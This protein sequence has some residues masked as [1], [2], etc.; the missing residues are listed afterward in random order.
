MTGAGY[1]KEW[2]VSAAPRIWEVEAI[3][4]SVHVLEGGLARKDETATVGVFRVVQ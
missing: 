2:G 4:G 3:K 1:Q